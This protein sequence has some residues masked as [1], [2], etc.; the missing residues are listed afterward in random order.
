MTKHY[1]KHLNYPFKE[2]KDIYKNL[3]LGLTISLGF[4]I[5]LGSCKLGPEFQKAPVET[6]ESYINYSLAPSEEI[7]LLWWNLF[8]DN[9]LDTLIAAAL[10]NNKD[11]QIAASRLESAKINIG[12]TKADQ[13]PSIGYG[14]GITGAG[15]SGTGAVS[16]GAVPEISWEIGFWGKYRRMNEAAQAN[17]LATQYAQQTVQ[18]GIV[19][20]VA[21]IYHTILAS[22]D[23]LQI[24]ESTLAS[25][26]SGLIIM[27]DKFEGGLISKMDLNQAQIQRDVAATV[28]PVYKRLIATNMNALNI[29]LGDVPGDI[30]M[31][32]AFYTRDYELDIPVGLPSELLT[33][34]P[35]IRQSEAIYMAKN[36]QIGIAEALRWPSLSL[37]GLLGVASADL[38]GTTGLTYS[39]GAS[40]FGPLFEFGKNKDRVSL[41]EQDA[42]VA[43]LQYQQTVLQAFR[44]VEDALVNISTY[45]EE[46]FAQE[47]RTYTAMES[48]DLAYIR[49][50][51]GS[52][53][54]LEV[55]EQ[56]RQAFSSQLDLLTNRLNL[57]NS[58]ITLYKVLGGGWMLEN[59]YDEYLKENTN[60]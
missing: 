18:L 46:L 56:Q 6:P 43:M 23:Q 21:S 58:Y 60:N 26:D 47:S 3:F 39:L 36:A 17:Y 53:T 8:D 51:E 41:A 19:S 54:Y 13:Y 14:V 22:Y 45:R 15:T 52:T 29:L 31:G 30:Q 4:S 57:I 24:A 49:Y 44:E 50:N 55:L 35:D 42:I 1:K 32:S 12:Y 28:V 33:R 27:H 16:F 38:S 7:N 11:V 34:R 10:R 20:T 2:K 48:E 37:T 25:R 5:I 40:L 59:E 9:I